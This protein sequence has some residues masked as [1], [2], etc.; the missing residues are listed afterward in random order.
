MKCRQ[1]DQL[2]APDQKVGTAIDKK[3]TRLLFGDGSE[4]LVEFPLAA[5]AQKQ[6]TQ[7]QIARSL[8]EIS[9]TGLGFGNKLIA[10]H[11]YQPAGDDRAPP[12][13]KTTTLSFASGLKREWARRFGS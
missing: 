13:R 6:Q 9:R 12:T 8:L 11:G 1:S 5:D 10:K 7:P 2:I 3:R 4:G